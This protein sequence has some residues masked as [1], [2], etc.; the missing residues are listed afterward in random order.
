MATPY[1]GHP[2]SLSSGEEEEIVGADPQTRRGARVGPEVRPLRRVVA[3]SALRI[4]SCTCSMSGSLRV[5][6]GGSMLRPDA[7]LAAVQGELVAT[8]PAGGIGLG[9]RGKQTLARVR[10][11]DLTQDRSRLHR[12]TRLSWHRY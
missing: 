6:L 7:D 2:R 10:E 11:D 5:I 4:S 3:T 9:D 12:A 1:H 8:D